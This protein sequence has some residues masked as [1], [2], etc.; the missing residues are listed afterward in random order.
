[1]G[2]FKYH[3]LC[4]QLLIQIL[5]LTLQNLLYGAVPISDDMEDEISLGAQG[6]EVLKLLNCNA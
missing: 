1:M 3:F 2:G 5:I 4:C 6:P